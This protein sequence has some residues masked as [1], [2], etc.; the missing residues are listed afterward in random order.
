MPGRPSVGRAGNVAG[1]KPAKYRGAERRSGIVA[2]CS[3]LPAVSG[4]SDALG[5]IDR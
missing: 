4:R 2:P 5:G 3:T 1:K